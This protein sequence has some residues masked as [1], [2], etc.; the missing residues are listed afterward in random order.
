MKIL[1]GLLL[2]GLTVG[3]SSQPV[4]EELRP[5]PAPQ[6]VVANTTD[7]RVAEMEVVIGELLDRI[8]VMNAR[9][10]KL[11]QGVPAPRETTARRVVDSTPPPTAPETR[12]AA[13]AAVSRPAGPPLRG[14]ALGEA[15]RSALELFGKGRLDD[16][17]ST[18]QRVYDS[19]TNGELADN[20]LYWIAETYFV[21]AKYADAIRIYHQITTDYSDQNKA[22]DAMLK[23]GLAHAKLGDLALARRTFEELIAKYPYSTPAA[24]ARHEI[25]R[26]QY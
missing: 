11:E 18:F 10:Q 20:A 7:P 2:L 23:T 13:P 14:A 22:P 5:Q 19:D 15:Y 24:A 9:L 17:R 26:I 8:E 6:P 21:R 16:A 12:T 1:A 3:C 25:K 4:D